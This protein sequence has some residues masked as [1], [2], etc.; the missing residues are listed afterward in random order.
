M[1][2]NDNIVGYDPQTGQPIYDNQN[3]QSP[4]MQSMNGQP[5]QQQVQPQMQSMNAQM[6]QPVQ[7]QMQSS[8]EQINN[9]KIKVDYQKSKMWFTVRGINIYIIFLFL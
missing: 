7:P 2:Q 8:S 9:N 5:T 3:N 4:Q 1:E 6:Q